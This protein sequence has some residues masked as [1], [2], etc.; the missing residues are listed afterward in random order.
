[1][2]ENNNAN[3]GILGRS[4]PAALGV[5]SPGLFSR[6]FH[7]DWVETEAEVSECRPL[8]SRRYYDYS[9]G[10]AVGGYFVNFSYTVNGR[11][12]DGVLISPAEVQ[13]HDK[14]AI[15]YNPRSPAMNNTFESESGWVPYLNYFVNG[16]LLLIVLA[17]LIIHFFFHIP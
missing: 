9:G 15:R 1:L 3:I 12:F 4:Q 7:R 11:S 10:G 6:I 17:I 5:T 2:R 8:R 16:A 13:E 14:F